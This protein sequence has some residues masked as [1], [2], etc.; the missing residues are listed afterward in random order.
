MDFNINLYVV[1]NK[2]DFVMTCAF[3]KLLLSFFLKKSLAYK[4]FHFYRQVLTIARVE[5]YL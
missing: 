3:I 2:T 4:N 5:N 1:A